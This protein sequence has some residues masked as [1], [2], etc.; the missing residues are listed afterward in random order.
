MKETR[1]LKPKDY[2]DWDSTKKGRAKG[3]YFGFYKI[4]NS[5]V[6]DPIGDLK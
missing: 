3:R 1:N 5:L 4:N 2:M 6:L